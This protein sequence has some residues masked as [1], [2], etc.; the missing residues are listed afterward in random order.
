MWQDAIL[1]HLLSGVNQGDWL[2]FEKLNG[3]YSLKRKEQPVRVILANSC[4]LKEAATAVFF[5]FFAGTSRNK[6]QGTLYR[7]WF[8]R[9]IDN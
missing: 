2:L 5:S 4:M 3:N 6:V 8:L 1:F 7:G 9:C